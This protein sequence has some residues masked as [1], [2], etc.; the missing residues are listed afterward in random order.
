MGADVQIAVAENFNPRCA[1]LGNPF[2]EN[3]PT[4]TAPVPPLAMRVALP[5][6]DAPRG[7][8]ELK[9]VK[10][11]VSPPPAPLT[12]VPLL[13]M[14]ALPAVELPKTVLPGLTISKKPSK[15]VAP[16]EAPLTT[17]AVIGDGRIASGRCTKK[18]TKGR[19]AAGPA[20][21][22][23]TFVRDGRITSS[24]ALKECST[25]TVSPA[26]RGRLVSED[27]VG[28]G[29]RATKIRVAASAVDLATNRAAVVDESAIGCGR[30][31]GEHCGATPERLTGS[32]RA[33]VGKSATA[34]ARVS[35]KVIKPGLRLEVCATVRRKEGAAPCCRTVI[36]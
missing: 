36:E 7:L 33:V 14:V 2:K 16:P 13:M 21:H 3:F 11:I 19:S 28:G 23:P 10:N 24:R 32:R 8:E 29:R 34:C 15:D 17:P 6:V 9:S 35:L 4:L 31:V 12:L 30:A 22:Y 18:A 26:D 25:A 1:T 5:A 27:A 20:P